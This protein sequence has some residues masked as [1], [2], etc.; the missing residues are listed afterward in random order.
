MRPPKKIKSTAADALLGLW[1]VALSAFVIATLYFAR[2]IFIP[3]ALSAL[4][5]FL[6]SPL[7]T[8]IE[9]WIGRIA[10]VLLVV[11]LIFAMTG[12]AGWMLTRQ[13]VDLATKLPEYKGNIAAKLH[14][15]Q[16]PKGGAFTK[17]SAAVEDL[18]KELPGGSAAI[19]LPITQGAG[20][21]DTTQL[22]ARTPGAG[23]GNFTGQSDGIDADDHRPDAGPLGHRG[24]RAG[25]GD[26]HAPAA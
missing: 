17:I 9:R 24:A 25:A 3:L 22:P 26:L 21:P 2:D 15:F 6:L 16:L 19:E 11:T 18:K 10:A 13:L 14:A 7:V 8:R 12:A 20:R 23:G 5:T 4:L 1:A